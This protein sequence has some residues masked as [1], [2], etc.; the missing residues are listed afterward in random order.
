MSCHDEFDYA[1]QAL[2]LRCMDY[3]LKPV[4]YTTLTAILK[5]AMDTVEERRHRAELARLK[6]EQGITDREIYHFDTPLTPQHEVECL[7]AAGF[8]SVAV[9]KNWAATYT[10]Q[11]IP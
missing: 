4:R 8:S 2:S 11:A 7:K 5:K 1:R 9:L 6:Q 10:I 3:V